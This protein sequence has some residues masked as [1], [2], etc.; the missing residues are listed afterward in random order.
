MMPKGKARSA[1]SGSYVTKVYAAKHPKTTVVE[2]A[3]KPS[4]RVRAKVIDLGGH[5]LSSFAAWMLVKMKGG[6]P[7][8]SMVR[9]RCLFVYKTKKAATSDC[10]EGERVV[11]ITVVREEA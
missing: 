10:L 9:G 7:A 5:A 11:R 8:Q 3:G 6:A 4:R 2:S 1:V